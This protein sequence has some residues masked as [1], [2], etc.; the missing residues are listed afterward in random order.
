MVNLDAAQLALPFQGLA[1]AA[2]LP[3]F[4]QSSQPEQRTAPQAPKQPR[5]LTIDQIAGQKRIPS[6]DFVLKLTGSF[7]SYRGGDGKPK[8]NFGFLKNA[9]HG[10]E[11]LP[12]L[13]K[14]YSF[15]NLDEFLAFAAATRQARLKSL[16][17]DQSF[18]SLV[19]QATP[20]QLFDAVFGSKPG[21]LRAMPEF[22][23][24]KEVTVHDPE[25]KRLS[26]YTRKD[27]PLEQRLQAASQEVLAQMQSE[28]LARPHNY[29]F[30]TNYSAGN[31][32]IVCMRYQPSFPTSKNNRCNKGYAGQIR[33]KLLRR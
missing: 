7:T 25:Y 1:E 6:I 23:K 19:Q 33:L 17:G 22:N 5:I 21:E 10:V 15:L 28:L 27:H 32:N 24:E 29:V 20:Y 18:A 2:A 12:S 31:R 30:S 8:Y 26:P 3:D 13:A 16:Q 4:E 14:L 11:D 9:C